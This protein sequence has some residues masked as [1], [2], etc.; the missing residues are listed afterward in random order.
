MKGIHVPYIELTNYDGEVV[1]LKATNIL[2]ITRAGCYVGE[3]HKDADRYGHAK[4]TLVT[5]NHMS[6]YVNELP[7][8]IRQLI[9]DATSGNLQIEGIR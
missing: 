6:Y 9:S 7:S 1:H 3:D 2:S 5:I 4:K 8:E